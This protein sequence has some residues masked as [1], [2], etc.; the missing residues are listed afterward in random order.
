MV[1]WVDFRSNYTLANML[2]GGSED[3]SAPGNENL[4]ASGNSTTSNS[5][6]ADGGNG[7]T[8]KTAIIVGVVV[9]V[10]GALLLG[11]LALW[12][13][14]RHRAKKEREKERKPE[15][16]PYVV[17]E[18]ELYRAASSSNDAVDAGAPSAPPPAPGQ[19]AEPEPRARRVVQ[20][21]DAE[22]AVEYLPPRYRVWE[23]R[24]ETG[25]GGEGSQPGPS[26][27]RAAPEGA[28]TSTTPLPAVE[29]SSTLKDDYLRAALDTVPGSARGPNSGTPTQ[30]PSSLKEEYMRSFG[31]GSAA[32]LP[33]G[34]P[35]TTS[36]HQEAQQ[37]GDME[38]L[39]SP[40]EARDTDN[41]AET[42]SATPP[43][44]TLK[45]DYKR[46]FP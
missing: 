17:S 39:H 3:L 21:Q 15:V 22:E 45:D 9:G 5:E 43:E 8:N 12:L 7:G 20:E 14:R 28:A 40:L 27:S 19:A 1:A 24:E 46:A 2:A 11:A 31:V 10:G 18:K 23:P 4:S 36:P 33:P 41:T 26:R 44:P 25:D 16:K 38:R 6:G 13:V 37:Q 32:E 34:S 30:L 35:G 42:T 29:P